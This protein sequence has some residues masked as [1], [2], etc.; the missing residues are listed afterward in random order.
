VGK[1][2]SNVFFHFTKGGN[3]EVLPIPCIVIINYFS[4]SVLFF[5]RSTEI[6]YARIEQGGNFH[7]GCSRFHHTVVFYRLMYAFGSENRMEFTVMAEC[8]PVI[9]YVLYDHLVVF[10]C[11]VLTV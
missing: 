5:Q 4:E 7:F 9:Q 10:L 6:V 8:Y 1:P 3:G 2:R 11:L